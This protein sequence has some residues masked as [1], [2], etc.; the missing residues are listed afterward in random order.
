M[1]VPPAQAHVQNALLQH[2]RVQRSSE[3]PVFYGIAHKETISARDLIERLNKTADIAN[4]QGGQRKCEGLYLLLREEALIWWRSLKAHGVDQTNWDQVKTA[5]LKYYEPKY[6]AVLTCNNLQD[7]HQRPGEPVHRYYLRLFDAL[8]KFKEIQPALGAV[9]HAPAAGANLA[10]A[11]MIAAKQEGA[12][13][14]DLFMRRQL[15]LAGLSERY[16]AK[17]MEADK[18]TLGETVDYAIELERI[19]QRD[20]KKLNVIQESDTGPTSPEDWDDE[21]VAAINAIRLRKGKPPFRR[22]SANQGAAPRREG[23]GGPVK[24]R[25]CKKLGHM[26]KECRSRLR[27]NAPMVDAEGKPFRKVHAVDN[28]VYPDSEKGQPSA[29]I[30]SIQQVDQF[31]SLNW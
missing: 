27:A 22:F 7:L 6:S 21:E 16:R 9:R 13:E 11:D 19:Y 24:C 10:D 15:F 17:A 2:D 1:A 20:M 8:E 14:Q 5:F 31:Q 12:D 4:W 23:F 28:P 25:Y 26:Q 3:L 18:A 29:T 30:S